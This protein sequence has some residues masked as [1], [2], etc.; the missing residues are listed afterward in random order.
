MTITHEDV[1]NNTRLPFF[2]CAGSDIFN[3]VHWHQGIEIGCLLK[4]KDL[5]F[6][7][8][9]Q[10]YH[11]NQGDVWAVNRRHIHS[12]TG[13][14]QNW[15]YFCLI[16][17][18]DFLLSQ[19]PSSKNWNLSLL[20]QKSSPNQA[21]FQK[22]AKEMIAIHDL[23]QA[24]LTD[25]TRLLILSH[26]FQIIV[27]L[28]QNFNQPK[29][30]IVTPNNNL[31]EEV[32]DFINQNFTQNY[33][34]EDIAHKFKVSHVT[35]NQ[36]L[37]QSTHMS[38]AEYLRLVRLMHARQLLLTTDKTIDVIASESGFSNAHVLSRNFKRWKEKTP[39]EYRNAF[40]Q[41]FIESLSN[42]KS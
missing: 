3:E 6:A 20:G 4:G 1:Q 9:G 22:L 36:Q 2:Y 10:T 41:Y 5:R 27:L 8:N 13:K 37:R 14:P 40:R 23:M 32:I 18:D 7:I 12:S 21:A 34:V 42:Q 39:T 15:D 28:D 19:F 31:N 26:L 11:F 30:D 17:D 38:T 29:I 35:L 24:K 33:S 25:C 16:I